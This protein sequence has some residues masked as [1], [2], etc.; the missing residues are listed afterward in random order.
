[1]SITPELTAQI[2]RYH[3]AE[4]WPVGTISSQLGVHRETVMRVL[5]QAGVTPNVPAQRASGVT[6]Y[7]PFIEQT[8]KQFP[9]L[10]ASR[11]YAMVA[12]RGYG[13]RPD[14]FRHII[15]RHRPPRPTC[16]C[17]PCPANS[18]NA[19]GDTLATSDKA[20]PSAH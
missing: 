10:T 1:M 4:H 7:M 13:G 5:T 12:Q 3:H 6:P 16:A 19:T 11:L 15:A 14:H 17:A 20:R 2:L 8:L 18:V 9:N